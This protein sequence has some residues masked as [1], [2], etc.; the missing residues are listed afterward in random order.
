MLGHAFPKNSPP[1]I[2]PRDPNLPRGL[3]KP[4]RRLLSVDLVKLR[5]KSTLRTL[6]P[7]HLLVLHLLGKNT[8]VTSYAPQARLSTSLGLLTLQ[9]SYRPSPILCKPPNRPQ[10]EGV[11]LKCFALEHWVKLLLILVKQVTSPFE[12]IPRG[13]APQTRKHPR[14]NE[15]HPLN[16]HGNLSPPVRASVRSTASSAIKLALIKL[17]FPLES[18]DLT[19]LPKTP[20]IRLLRCKLLLR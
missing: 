9:L 2:L 19:S 8:T 16:L 14:V 17:K 1:R 13:C 11:T 4:T 18:V 5:T 7:S 10:T 15:T 6:P 20:T 12:I 3:V